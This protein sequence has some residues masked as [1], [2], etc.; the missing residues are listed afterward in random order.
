MMHKSARVQ[1]SSD[2]K[3]LTKWLS[4][5]QLDVCCKVVRC[6]KIAAH[7]GAQPLTLRNFQSTLEFLTATVKNFQ[8][9][10]V[11]TS[12]KSVDCRELGHD[13]TQLELNQLNH[14][15]LFRQGIATVAR[16]HSGTSPSYVPH[17]HSGGIQSSESTVTLPLETSQVWALAAA[18]VQRCGNHPLSV[19]GPPLHPW[20]LDGVGR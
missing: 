16:W 18:H 12:L 5:I 3:Q 11:P 19:R 13:K 14:C 4:Y 2:W 20:S 9:T 17:R 6:P 1:T 7:S 15:C 8:Q 10:A